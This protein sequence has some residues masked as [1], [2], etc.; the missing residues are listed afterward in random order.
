MSQVFGLSTQDSPY[1]QEVHQRLQLP[2]DLLS[3]ERPE[4]QEALKL[5]TF[6]WQGQ[7]VIRRLS[8][9]IEDGKVVK[10]WYPIFPPDSNVFNVLEWLE[11]SDQKL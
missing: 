5:P 8:L 11:E 2:Y 4:F 10:W 6:D 1:Q 9:A 3:D 7:K